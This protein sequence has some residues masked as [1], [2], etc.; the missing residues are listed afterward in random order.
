LRRSSDNTNSAAPDSSAFEPVADLPGLPPLNFLPIT[1]QKWV[2]ILVLAYHV[3][4]IAGLSILI[5]FQNAARVF[6]VTKAT[7]RFAV[8]YLPGVVGAVSTIMLQS[9]G[10][11]LARMTPF[12]RLAEGAGDT[13]SNPNTA[14]KTLFA[15]YF[16]GVPWN[17][18]LSNQEWLLFV[19]RFTSV[20]ANGVIVPLKGSL[21]I[22]QSISDVPE[23]YHVTTSRG[24]GITLSIMFTIVICVLFCVTI[25]TWNR[26]TGLKWDPVSMADNI[27][28]F[29]A[30]N[31]LDS[32]DTLEL[33]RLRWNMNS[34]PWK[35]ARQL[36]GWRDICK[37]RHRLG[38]WLHKETGTYWHGIRRICNKNGKIPSYTVHLQTHHF[39]RR[40]VR[41]VFRSAI[42]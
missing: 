38:Y 18:I 2:L 21:L 12:I 19:C 35:V 1:L 6:H 9:V 29:A 14:E 28:L 39:T 31:S 10:N 32:L 34:V 42:H 3:G 20:V 36:D 15:P 13:A 7:S 25:S 37:E 27:T 8:Y 22:K 23:T 26:R 16:P 4:I 40:N 33:E 30:S 11:S 41:R 17:I 24:T 5:Y